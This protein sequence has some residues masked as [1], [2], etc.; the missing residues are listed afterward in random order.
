[1]SAA[2]GGI[3]STQKLTTVVCPT[4]TGLGFTERKARVLM[5]VAAFAL[6]A[7]ATI[8]ER[9]KSKIMLAE[10]VDFLFCIFMFFSPDLSSV[11]SVF[12]ILAYC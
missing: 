5:V 1:M 12:K 2:V 8:I 3:G 11:Q 7:P 6:I 9:A 10:I 4:C